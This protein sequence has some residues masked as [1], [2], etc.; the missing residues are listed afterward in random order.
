M[1]EIR[2]DQKTGRVSHFLPKITIKASI[3]VLVRWNQRNTSNVWPMP[4]HA[5]TS[6]CPA[7]LLEPCLYCGQCSAHVDTPSS[8]LSSAYY[9]QL[10]YVSKPL[11]TL[12]LSCQA[13]A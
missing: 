13:A 1:E 6:V 10:E 3:P 11:D 9:V 7:A 8:G 4:W 2:E 12:L 5:L